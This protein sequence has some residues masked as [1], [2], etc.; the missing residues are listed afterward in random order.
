MLSENTKGGKSLPTLLKE[1]QIK[2]EFQKKFDALGVDFK[3]M[4]VDLEETDDDSKQ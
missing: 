2:E 1:K 4:Y 3:V